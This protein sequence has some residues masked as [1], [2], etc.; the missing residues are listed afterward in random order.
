MPA[1]KEN[2]TMKNGKKTNRNK[3]K[4]YGATLVSGAIR[5][6]AFKSMMKATSTILTVLAAVALI[7]TITARAAVAED[8]PAAAKD[9][10]LLGSGSQVTSGTGY[11][12]QNQSI[13]QSIRYGKRGSLGGINLVWDKKADLK[14]AHFESES[15]SGSIKYGEKLALKIDNDSK[16]YVRYDHRD[17]GVNL[18]WSNTPVFE[19]VIVGGKE[20]D[21]VKVGESF[22]LVNKVEKDFL[23]YAKRGGEAINLRWYQDRNKGGYFDQAKKASFEEA[24]KVAV[25]A[26]TK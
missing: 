9:W 23:I 19:W 13:D 24:K 10:K 20:G 11:C 5:R 16:P 3:G 6:G 17:I 7:L 22:A 12:F 8:M 4:H 15:G 18:N 26:A 1:K 21:P 2:I 14:N 25:E